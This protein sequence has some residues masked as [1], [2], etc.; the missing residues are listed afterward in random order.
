MPPKKTSAPVGA[1]KKTETKKK[2]KVIEVSP[3]L[4]YSF[5]ILLSVNTIPLP[6]SLRMGSEECR[7]L[8]YKNYNY[9]A[10]PNIWPAYSQPRDGLAI[11]LE[12]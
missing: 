11:F 8:L 7:F 3:Y 9:L 5:I 12:H 10:S 4:L 6:P 2:E 1:S